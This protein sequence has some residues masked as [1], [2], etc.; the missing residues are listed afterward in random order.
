MAEPRQFFAQ[1]FGAAAQP[2]AARAGEQ[3]VFEHGEALDQHELLMDHADPG[4]DRI[5]RRAEANRLTVDAQFAGIGF[6]MPVEQPHQG[7]FAG[8][9]FA[10]NAVHL[11][12]PDNQIDAVIRLD[13]AKALV[14]AAEFDGRSQRPV[15]APGLILPAMIWAR[16]SSALACIAGVTSALLLSSI[17]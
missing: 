3:Q 8:A 12:G 1:P 2:A 16:A 11:T 17:A 6:E 5:L 7:R 10:D 9:V 4:S 14:D 15:I 13:R